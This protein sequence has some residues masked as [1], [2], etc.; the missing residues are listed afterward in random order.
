MSDADTA[1]AVERVYTYEALFIS[2]AASEWKPARDSQGRILNDRYLINTS[3]SYSPTFQPQVDLF[4][5]DEGA[6]IFR[7]L[8][9]RLTGEQIAIF[10]GGELVTA[11]TVNET[12]PDGRAVITGQYTPESA[13]KLANDIKTGIVPAPIY[14]SS[15]RTVD[16]KIGED[17]LSVVMIAGIVG[18]VVILVFL[19][20]VYRVSGLFAGFALVIYTL[21]LL[22]VAKWFGVVLTLASIAGL[23]LS[24]GLAIDANILIFERIKEELRR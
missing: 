8:T 3:V 10:V 23:I 15:E 24:I 7:E 20:V 1:N 13:A 5:N 9:Q 16:A 4:F 11:P 14:L 19:I 17:S 21:L 12:I 22:A 6:E 2:A 18:L